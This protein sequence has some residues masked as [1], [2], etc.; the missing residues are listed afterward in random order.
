MME[1]E[2]LRDREKW[3]A[4]REEEECR[5]AKELQVAKAKSLR[6]AKAEWK[7]KRAKM[8]TKMAQEQASSSTARPTTTS[9]PIAKT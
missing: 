4:A 7:K 3:T 8:C 2:N 1:E 5:E 6:E 9:I